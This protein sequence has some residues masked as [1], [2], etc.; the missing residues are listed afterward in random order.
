MIRALITVTVLMLFSLTAW[1]ATTSERDIALAHNVV[2]IAYH[3]DMTQFW[4]NDKLVGVLYEDDYGDN[5]VKAAMSNE[6][7][8]YAYIDDVFDIYDLLVDLPVILING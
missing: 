4:F 5:F 3:S 2:I 8:N 1:T 6:G 7:H